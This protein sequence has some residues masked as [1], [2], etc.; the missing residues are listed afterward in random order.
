V[1]ACAELLDK[2]GGHPMACGFSIEGE[3]N[4]REFKQKLSALAAERLTPE[5][6]APKLIIDAV[7]EF[8]R[9]NLGLVEEINALAPFGQNNPQPHFASF[10]LRIDDL[11]LMG[12]ERQHIKLRLSAAQEKLS[13]SFWAI[14]F[15]SAAAYQELKI[16]DVINLAYYLDINEFNGRRE[17]QL[18]IIDWQLNK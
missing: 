18:K 13:P 16:G 2:Y 1:S 11:I 3:E 17:V 9:I 10:N 7:L 5:I 4:L 12:S 15:S 6:L 14:A 8:G